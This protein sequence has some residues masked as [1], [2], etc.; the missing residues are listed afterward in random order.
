MMADDNA[1]KNSLINLELPESIDNAVKNITDKP[2]ATIGETISD[3]MFLV[4]GGLNQKA[5]LK[6][7][8]YAYDLEVFKKDLEKK[9]NAV[10]EE[11]RLDPNVQTVCTALDN[12]RYCVEEKELREMFA[13]LIANSIDSSKTSYVHP[14]YGEIIKQMTSFD[15]MVFNEMTCQYLLPII[16]ITI[17]AK[18]RGSHAGSKAMIWNNWG[19]DERVA[20][21]L[22]NLSRLKL[23][24]IKYDLYY[25][26][27]RAY[28]YLKKQ[29]HVAERISLVNNQLGAGETIGYDKGIV[30]ITDYGKNFHKVC[31]SD[32]VES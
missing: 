32:E 20:T 7:A 29:A 6:R 22:D 25:T 10:P 17:K 4:F 16:R 15:A 30:I 13:S 2:S 12:M 26:D 14:S 1:T 31:T 21:A 23:I 27:D 5:A 18:D 8:K 19:D 3:C 28:D 11:N 24:D 9:L